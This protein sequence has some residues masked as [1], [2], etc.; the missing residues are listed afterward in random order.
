MK[1]ECKG[2]WIPIEIYENEELSIQDIF[3]LCEIH[4]LD[5]GAGCFAKNEHFCKRMKIKIA[6]LEGRYCELAELAMDAISVDNIDEAIALLNNCKN[7][8]LK[9]EMLEIMIEELYR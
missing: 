9:I 3:L 4:S 1:K 5:N 2:L 6:H 8:K 7:I